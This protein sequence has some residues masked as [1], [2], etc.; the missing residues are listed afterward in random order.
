MDSQ[1]INAWLY[2]RN[3]NYGVSANLSASGLK[4]LH[5]LNTYLPVLKT[6]IL[7]L[8]STLFAAGKFVLLIVQQAQGRSSETAV[9]PHHNNQSY[10]LPYKIA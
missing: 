1:E 5:S 2:S 6:V 7:S 3:R 9:S 8:P 4:F 10:N